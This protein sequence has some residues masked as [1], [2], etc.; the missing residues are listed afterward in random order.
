MTEPDPHAAQRQDSRQWAQTE[1][2]KMAFKH[3]K[4]AIV[5]VMKH[6]KSFLKRTQLRA[7]CSVVDPALSRG[8]GLANI[9]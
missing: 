3:K 2:W 7:T 6:W 8:L 9:L 5:R 4:V 1:T